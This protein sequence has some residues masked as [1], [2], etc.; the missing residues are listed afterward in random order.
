MCTE[1]DRHGICSTMYFPYWIELAVQNTI[2]ECAELM[3]KKYKGRNG[4]VERKEEC[5]SFG[6][7]WR[8]PIQL[9]IEKW[10]QVR[11]SFGKGRPCLLQCWIQELNLVQEVRVQVFKTS[12]IFCTV[13]RMTLKNRSSDPAFCGLSPSPA[14]IWCTVWIQQSGISWSTDWS[15]ICTWCYWWSLEWRSKGCSSS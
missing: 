12:Y 15:N 14:S 13:T 7:S 10:S 1:L 5:T 9:F 4:E 2:I 11:L 8:F 6:L 3:S